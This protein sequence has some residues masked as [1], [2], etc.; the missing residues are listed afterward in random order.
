MQSQSSSAAVL[1][2]KRNYKRFDGISVLYVPF[3]S[4]G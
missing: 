1:T 4:Y 3:S 2:S